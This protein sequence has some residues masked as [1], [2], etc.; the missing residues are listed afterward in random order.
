MTM[1]SNSSFAESSF[2]P[3]LSADNFITEDGIYQLSIRCHNSWNDEIDYTKYDYDTTNKNE[4]DY[5]LHMFNSIKLSVPKDDVM[6]VYD[7]PSIFVSSGNNVICHFL[8][9]YKGGYQNRYYPG[10][11]MGS[12]GYIY[13]RKHLEVILENI[14]AIKE[15]KLTIH[16]MSYDTSKWA[17]KD[18]QTAYNIGL[19]PDIYAINYTD[20][21]TR[22]GTCQLI[23]NLL[24]KIGLKGNEAI[25]SIFD[26]T[27]NSDVAVLYNLGIINGKSYNK[28]VPYDIVTR[29]ELAK[30]LCGVYEVTKN[31]AG[32]SENY[33][34]LFSDYKQISAWAKP[35]VAKMNNL[36]ILVGDEN[37]N[38]NPKDCCTKEQVIV[39]VLRLYNAISDEITMMQVNLNQK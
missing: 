20:N 39:A 32:R 10:S 30:I 14:E 38:F 28:F 34:A 12:G 2:S 17:E 5:I 11:D 7:I 29:E 8:T 31:N 19:I 1:L 22:L 9:N 24:D 21:I 16:S 35:Y 26:D 13:E 6:Y 18:I 37:G 15:G 27:N 25:N 3:L 33:D 36:K 4:I 23:G